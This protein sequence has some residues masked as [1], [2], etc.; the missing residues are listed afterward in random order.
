M[1]KASSIFDSFLKIQV[2]LNKSETKSMYPLRQPEDT[3][4]QDTWT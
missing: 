3:A 2:E 1:L 4:E